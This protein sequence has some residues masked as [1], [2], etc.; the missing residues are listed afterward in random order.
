MNPVFEIDDH[1][2]PFRSVNRLPPSCIPH[3]RRLGRLNS[4]SA[5]GTQTSTA[6][7]L[8]EVPD[9][10]VPRWQNLDSRPAG[11]RVLRLF[12]SLIKRLYSTT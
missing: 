2:V 6:A 9:P 4:A 11:A 10:T 3:Q 7:V 5:R 8:P 1:F 12:D